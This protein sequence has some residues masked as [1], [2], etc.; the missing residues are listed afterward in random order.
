MQL[1]S[2]PQQVAV[3]SHGSWLDC[4]NGSHISH[5]VLLQQGWFCPI[6]TLNALP[7]I[8]T[9]ADELFAQKKAHSGF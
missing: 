3:C 7:S 2:E 5:A 8:T 6:I 9:T 1:I 4:G